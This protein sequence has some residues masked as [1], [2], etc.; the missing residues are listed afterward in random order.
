MSLEIEDM[1]SRS[2]AGIR[3]RKAKWKEIKDRIKWKRMSRPIEK[4]EEAIQAV[5]NDPRI[6]DIRIKS[7]EYGG[8]HGILFRMECH[9]IASANHQDTFSISLCGEHGLMVG[10]IYQ[11]KK[12]I[13]KAMKDIPAPRAAVAPE[14]RF[15]LIG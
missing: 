14:E 4:R 10:A 15:E 8:K 1:S 2:M 13:F 7:H 9:C 5:R 3:A 12:L 11:I 6:K